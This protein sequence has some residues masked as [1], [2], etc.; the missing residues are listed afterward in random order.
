MRE[1]TLAGVRRKE[2]D[3]RSTRGELR[4]ERRV[5][6]A[7]RHASGCGF[8]STRVRSSALHATQE[9]REPNR[10]ELVGG[11]RLGGK[12]RVIAR[13]GGKFQNFWNLFR[14]IIRAW[15]GTHQPC[16][17][18]GGRGGVRELHC[19]RGVS[20]RRVSPLSVF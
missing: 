6:Q 15:E 3:P 4:L 10:T 20:F 9:P 1:K 14:Q 13:V 19:H 18:R 16:T 12:L 17:G 7:S 8:G 11:P 2:A 5:P